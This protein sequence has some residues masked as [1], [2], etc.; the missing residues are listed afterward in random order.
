VAILQLTDGVTTNGFVSFAF[1]IG[2]QA[3]RN[4]T[5]LNQITI[6]DNTNASP[7][8]SII[9]VANMGGTV[10]KVSVTISNLTHG[11]PD[12]I[13]ILLISPGGQRVMLMSDAG[14]TSAQPH[15][16]NNVTLRFDAAAAGLLSDSNQIT[17]GTYQPVNFA[18]PGQNTSD[19][20]ELPAP[21]PIQV[22]DPFPYTNTALSVFNNASP[23]GAWSLFV[24]DDTPGQNGSI[25]GWSLEIQTSDP[26]APS[27]GFSIADLAASVSGVPASAVIGAQYACTFTIT[28]RG[29]AP[30]ESV[31]LLDQMPA[32]L[33]LVSASVSAGTWSKVQGTLTWNVGSLPSGATAS[34]TLVSRPT[35]L[36]TL[37]S[38]ATVSAN[39]IDPN[40]ANNSIN[41]VTTVGGVP[42]LTVTRVGNNLRLSWPASSGFKLQANDTLN[43]ANWVDVGT[44]PQVDNGQNVLTVGVPG[45]ARF[46]RLRSP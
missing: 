36:G 9:N 25:G 31:A 34:M 10:T 6:R 40:P 23:N 18:G 41:M 17:S 5:N 4:F 37:S 19:R 39:Q 14:S 46:Y 22:I 38:T 29:P 27:A 1:T 3:T 44:A 45:S 7:Y 42:V 15:P 13:D 32:G 20:F 11:F 35:V 21:Q 2:G 43:P 33:A 28:N 8:P 12:D 30:A 16:V 24:M 26:V